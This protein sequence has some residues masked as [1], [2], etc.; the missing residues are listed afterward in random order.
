MYCTICSLQVSHHNHEKLSSLEYG[1]KRRKKK[2]F[3]DIAP[4]GF[5]LIL[6]SVQMTRIP[7]I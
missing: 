2:H 6:E 5:K 4:V 1:A 7:K 3:M